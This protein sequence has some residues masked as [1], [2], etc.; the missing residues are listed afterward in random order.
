M[1][2]TCL[3][4]KVNKIR[5]KL[6]Q[7]CTTIV[8]TQLKC[9]KKNIY[10]YIVNKIFYVQTLTVFTHKYTIYILTKECLGHYTSSCKYIAQ[11]SKSINN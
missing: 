5:Y 11:K 2:Y 6:F 4:I 1:Q 9:L 8:Y 3:Q 10:I 7:L